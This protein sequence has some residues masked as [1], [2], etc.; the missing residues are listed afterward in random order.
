M[1]ICKEMLNLVE[2]QQSLGT[3]GTSDM[4]GTIR[5]QRIYTPHLQK[6]FILT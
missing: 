4:L 5:N 3:W 2:Q 6:G 1:E